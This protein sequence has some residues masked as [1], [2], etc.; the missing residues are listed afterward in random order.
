MMMKKKK[1]S[2]TGRWPAMHVYHMRAG[3]L[4]VFF[5]VAPLSLYIYI[6]ILKNIYVQIHIKKMIYF[7]WI[8]YIGVRMNVNQR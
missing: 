3:V 8:E 2:S 5:C 4:C 1:S 7:G 6:D